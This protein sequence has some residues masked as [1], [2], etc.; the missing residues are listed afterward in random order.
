MI[1]DTSTLGS[2]VARFFGSEIQRIA[3]EEA[4]AAAEKVKQRVREAATKIAANV[5]ERMSFERMGAELVIRV[6]FKK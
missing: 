2:E 5:C 6:E 4:A 3:D 1:I